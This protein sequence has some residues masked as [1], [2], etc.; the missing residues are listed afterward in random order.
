MK[1]AR[2]IA[3]SPRPAVRHHRHQLHL[4]TRPR[5]LIRIIPTVAVLISTVLGPAMTHSATPSH[6]FGTALWLDGIDDYAS[7]PDSTILDLGTGAMTAFTVETFFYVPDLARNS[8]STLIYKR[9]AYALYIIFS[10]SGPDRIIFKIWAGPLTTDDRYIAREADLSADWHHLIAATFDNASTPGHAFMALYLDGN[11]D[12]GVAQVTGLYNSSS[13]LYVGG[14]GEAPFGG[15]IEE[16]RLSNTVRYSSDS[17]PVPTQPFAPDPFTVAL[18]HFDEAAGSTT[19][20]DVSGHAHTLSG[21]NGAQ[22]GSLTPTADITVNGADGPVESPSTA[23]LTATVALDPGGS[24]E[25]MADWWLVAA[26]P[27]GWY[28]FSAAAGTWVPGLVVTYQGPLVHLPAVAVLSMAGL[29]PGTY[30]STSAWTW[31]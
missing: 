18:W 26:T 15:R 31:R 19:F 1:P 30:H 25:A 9:N 28:S 17:F 3:S 6:L 5:R 4:L 12:E 21:Y 8:Q 13:L 10:D 7:A 14:Y 20:A 23:T 22:T 2:T 24:A 16:L 27:F 11:R 29:P